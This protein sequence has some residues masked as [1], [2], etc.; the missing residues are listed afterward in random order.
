MGTKSSIAEKRKWAGLNPD[1]QC[2]VC[3][4]SNTHY[5]IKAAFGP[6]QTIAIFKQ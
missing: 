2:T 4:T 5:G 3:I 1:R 6:G